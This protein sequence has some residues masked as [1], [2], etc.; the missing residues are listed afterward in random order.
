MKMKCEV[1]NAKAVDVWVN[2]YDSADYVWLCR[3]HLDGFED[4]FMTLE[5][6]FLD[7]EMEAL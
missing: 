7:I 1:C 2:P 4:T 3:D 5:Y 6:I